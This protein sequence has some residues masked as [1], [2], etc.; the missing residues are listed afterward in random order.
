VFQAIMEH[1]AWDK[2]SKIS[3]DDSANLN[4]YKI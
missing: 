1:P 2:A 4:S 3:I